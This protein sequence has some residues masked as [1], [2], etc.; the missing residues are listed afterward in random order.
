MGLLIAAM[1][2]VG[3]GSVAIWALGCF[4]CCALI[5][6]APIGALLCRRWALR[7]GWD[8]SRYAWLG[9]FY[10]ACGLM[11]WVYFAFRLNGRTPPRRLLGATYTA[12]FLAW[13]A[14]PVIAGFIHADFPGLEF[15]VWIPIVNLLTFIAALVCLAIAD[16]L[17]ETPQRVQI[18]RV[19][20][21]L[22]WSLAM[23][24]SLPYLLFLY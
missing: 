16:E 3:Y 22:L 1:F 6:T 2:I 23:L 4:A 24:T 9:A 15:L 18:L 13:L 14:G 10:W 20:P 21:S 11:P 17:P 7:Q 5:A 19:I 8:A 12:L